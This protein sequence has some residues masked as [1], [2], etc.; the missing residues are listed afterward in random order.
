MRCILTLVCFSDDEAQSR[1]TPPLP[2]TVSEA[3]D[4]SN[5]DSLDSTKATD[6]AGFDRGRDHRSLD[7]LGLVD[8]MMQY[9]PGSSKF[10]KYATTIAASLES[11][12][13]S[14][15]H[16]FFPC[17][18]FGR[19]RSRNDAL[20]LTLLFNSTVE[21]TVRS[22]L[23]ETLKRVQGARIRMKATQQRAPGSSVQAEG[24]MDAAELELKL[25][26]LGGME[27]LISICIDAGHTSRFCDSTR[28]SAR[29]L[30][31][32]LSLTT[33]GTN[34]LVSLLEHEMTAFLLAE[35]S[36]PRQQHDLSRMLLASDV[37]TEAH[38]GKGRQEAKKRHLDLSAV[39]SGHPRRLWDM[40]RRILTVLQA[41]FGRKQHATCFKLIDLLHVIIGMRART[42]PP[43]I[44]TELAAMSTTPLSIT[45]SMSSDGDDK[46]RRAYGDRRKSVSAHLNKSTPQLAEFHP[47]PEKENLA[48]QAKPSTTKLAKTARAAAMH[49]HGHSPPTASDESGHVNEEVDV[50][51]PLQVLKVLLQQ[52]F[53]LDNYNVKQQELRDILLTFCLSTRKSASFIANETN[54]ICTITHESAIKYMKSIADLIENRNCDAPET[55]FDESV[56]YHLLSQVQLMRTWK[57][58]G[59]NFVCGLLQPQ[60]VSLGAMLTRYMSCLSRL[61]S[62]EE[63]I[64]EETSHRRF[65]RSRHFTR[66]PYVVDCVVRF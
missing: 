11:Q 29:D 18:A 1:R 19:E 60:L 14:Q 36:S 22:A 48:V 50:D 25:I 46:D 45:A 20:P 17:P 40:I 23:S 49:R 10:E 53:D 41:C 32:L 39:L 30:L 21:A 12:L 35:I 65:V 51:F 63:L 28:G 27:S 42:L 4:P 55:T 54:R 13:A 24:E 61:L 43:P 52:L 58:K 44:H 7:F 47:D 37:L 8:R 26:N 56:F 6:D 66:C 31:D 62:I 34:S 5:Q 57:L 64:V 16:C 2:G 59:K 9:N 3:L 38:L 33:P 15:R